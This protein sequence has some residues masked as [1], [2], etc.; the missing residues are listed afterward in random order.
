[1]RA[2]IEEEA[3]ADN[4]ARQ[5]QLALKFSDK[6]AFVKSALIKLASLNL[7]PILC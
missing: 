3:L 7:A 1:M 2:G 6:F 5:V 4:E